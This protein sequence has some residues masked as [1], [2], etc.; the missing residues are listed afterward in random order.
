MFP[1]LSVE[2]FDFLTIF[3]QFIAQLNMQANFNVEADK[4][5]GEHRRNYREAALV[6]AETLPKNLISHIVL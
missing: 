4:F 1:W 5:L 3:S 6:W 2:H